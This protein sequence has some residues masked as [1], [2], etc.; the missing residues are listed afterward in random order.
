[1]NF[2]A[3][4]YD[5]HLGHERSDSPQQRLGENRGG[6]AVCQFSAFYLHLC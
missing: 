6:G 5:E 1:M 3:W 2:E 4:Y